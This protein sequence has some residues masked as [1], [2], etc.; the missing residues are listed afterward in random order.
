MMGEA[1]VVEKTQGPPATVESI[2]QDLTRLGMETGMVLLVHSSLRA[3]GWVSGGPVAV[4]L[5]LE[6]VLGP[7]GTLVMPTHSGDLSDPANWQNPPV[8]KDWWAIIRESMP[9]YNKDLTPTRKMGRLPETFRKQGGVLRSH[10][11]QVSFAA[12]GAEARKVTEGHALDFGLGE[13]SPLARIYDLAGYVLLLGVGYDNNTSFHLAEGRA[14]FPGKKTITSGAP[15]FKDG[16]R[17]WVEIKDIELD[18]SDFHELGESFEQ[19]KSCVRHGRVAQARCRL[20][21]QRELVD[22]AVQWMIK[23]RG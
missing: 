22:Y 2:R 14:S 13:G 15:I 23:N 4:I 20:M 9:A 18:V 19:E 16:K 5:A 1:E 10:H 8:P 6:Q 3:L 17:V 11:P 12:W 21:P 7:Q